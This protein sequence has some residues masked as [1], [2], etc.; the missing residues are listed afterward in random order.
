MNLKAAYFFNG[1][2]KVPSGHKGLNEKQ[3][4]ENVY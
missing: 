2:L 4:S 3:N 1:T